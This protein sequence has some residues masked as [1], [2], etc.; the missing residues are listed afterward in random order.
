MVRLIFHNEA[1]LNDITNRK[2]KAYNHSMFNVE[3]EEE[4]LFQVVEYFPAQRQIQ[5]DVRDLV[6]AVFRFGSSLWE[7]QDALDLLGNA[8]E[9][10]AAATA[11]IG[12][13]Q[14][15]PTNRGT[16]R[17]VYKRFKQLMSTS[18]RLSMSCQRNITLRQN[19]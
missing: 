16:D 3:K 11:I 17:Y 7:R 6:K 12:I 18:S 14:V 4:L 5:Q 9:I 19:D 8:N 13:L 10:V 1:C 2:Q 15:G